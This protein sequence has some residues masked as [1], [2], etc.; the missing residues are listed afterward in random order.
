MENKIIPIPPDNMLEDFHNK[1]KPL[2][3]KIILNQKEIMVLRQVRD[4]L[5]P[6]LVFGKLRVEEM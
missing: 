6:L 5:L 3:Q 1:I 4:V 2:F